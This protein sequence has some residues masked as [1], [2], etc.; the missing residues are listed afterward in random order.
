MKYVILAGGS[1]ERLWPHSRRDFPK[2]FLCFGDSESLLQKTVK[3]F[4]NTAAIEDIL[5]VTN[6]AYYHLIK[7]QLDSIDVR[8]C[9]QIIIEPERKNT[10]PAICLAMKYLKEELFV[11]SSETV[12]V[13]SSDHIL[14]PEETFLSAL[15]EADQ[16]AKK[17]VT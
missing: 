17:A 7:S 4:Y 13:C 1:G 10:A 16:V 2:Q 15:V 9:A 3:R 8:L 5:V 14:F 6:Q 12:L 11:A